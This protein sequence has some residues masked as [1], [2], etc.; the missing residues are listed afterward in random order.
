MDEMF[1][2]VFKTDLE[3]DFAFFVGLSKAEPVGEEPKG[4][5]WEGLNKGFV[6]DK[7]LNKN[8][9]APPQAYMKVYSKLGFNIK[10]KVTNQIL[11]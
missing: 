10:F 11:N 8:K 5:D 1:K 3:A 9:T 6:D 7:W 4:V 2:D